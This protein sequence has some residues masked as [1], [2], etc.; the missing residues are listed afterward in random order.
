MPYQRVKLS[1]SPKQ[2]KAALKGAKIRLPTTSIGTGQLV[3]LHPL[4]YKKVVN[5]KGGI[6]LELS[7]GEMMATA[8]HHGIIPTPTGSDMSGA[9]I[10][11]SIWSGIKSV[12]NFLKDT[13]VASTLADVAQ[14]AAKPFVGDTI[15]NAARG[16]LKGATGVGLKAKKRGKSSGL[17]LGKA[18]GSGL[19][20]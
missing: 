4:N 14:E 15:A 5:A 11:D 1:I 13:G 8:A 17:Y 16:A 7:P 2:Q 18:G 20:L 6:N 19:Y 12:G 10:F 3:L 9:G